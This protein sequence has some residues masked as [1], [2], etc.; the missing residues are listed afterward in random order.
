MNDEFWWYVARSTG[1]VCWALAAAAVIW[2]L[3]VTSKPFGKKPAPAW[4]LDLHRHLGG[5]SV[6]FLVLHVAALLLDSFTQWSLVD[7]IIPWAAGWNPGPVAGG[8]VAAW[9]L[10]AV[11]VS[12]LFQRYL[13]RRW[14]RRLHLTS[15]AVF[16]FGTV[17]FL[18]AGSDRTHPL[19]LATV[20]LT[21]AIVVALTIWRV[22]QA[23]RKPS[24]TPAAAAATAG[25]PSRGQRATLAPGT[26]R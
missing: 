6:L 13:P 16:V 14:W 10:V 7:V 15:Y 11:E 5:L 8:I 18:T 24:R 3:A 20:A 21:V 19:L 12:S 9:L 23:K 17:H 22:I 1:V 4:T 26:T 2:G 25:R